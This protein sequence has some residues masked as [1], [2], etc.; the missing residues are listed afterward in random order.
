[1]DSTSSILYLSEQTLDSLDISTG[2]IIQALEHH[3]MRL[4]N[5]TS[6]NTVIMGAD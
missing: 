1:M 3:Q 6:H 4:L 5:T 2:E